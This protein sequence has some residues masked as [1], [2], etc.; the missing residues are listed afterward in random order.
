[1]QEFDPAMKCTHSPHFCSP[2]GWVWY[3]TVAGGTFLVAA[4]AAELALAAGEL[5]GAELVDFAPCFESH[6]ESTIGTQR[7]Q[8]IASAPRS[9]T[10]RGGI[11]S[12]IMCSPLGD[13]HPSNFRHGS[14]AGLCVGVQTGHWAG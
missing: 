12:F 3:C 10:L 6:P 2:F 4:G 13:H 9:T 8:P 14:Q 7:P 1:M 5:A 11:S